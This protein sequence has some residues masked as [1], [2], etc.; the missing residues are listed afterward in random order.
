MQILTVKSHWSGSSFLKHY[1]YWNIAETHLGHSDAAQSQ[2]DH[3]A[4]HHIWEQHT[5]ELQA[6]AHHFV[7]CWQ[8]RAQPSRLQLWAMPRAHTPPQQDNQWVVAG[9]GGP[10]G[11]PDLLA[12]WELAILDKDILLS[13]IIV[14]SP[15]RN[16]IKALLKSLFPWELPFFSRPGDTAH[17]LLPHL[18]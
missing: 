2:G 8:S 15:P 5:C 10:G 1:K 14:P 4:G 17:P 7:L 18:S 6:S 12:A 16:S 3:G 9:W 11:S 13:C